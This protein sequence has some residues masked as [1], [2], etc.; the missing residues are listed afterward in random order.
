MVSF[1]ENGSDIVNRF[2]SSPSGRSKLTEIKCAL[3]YLAS[4]SYTKSLGKSSNSKFMRNCCE[5]KYTLLAVSYTHLT[6]P[7]NR[8]V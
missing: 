7:T 1:S 2:T 6:L 5:V 3:E 4:Y 8:E